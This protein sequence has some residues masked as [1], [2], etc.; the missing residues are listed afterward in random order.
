MAKTPAAQ[1]APETGSDPQ[2]ESVSFFLKVQESSVLEKGTE[3][4]LER[5]A[6]AIGRAHDKADIVIA[7]DIKVSN[8]HAIL[9]LERGTYIVFDRDSVSGTF[10]ND[11]EI[12]HG[13]ALAMGDRLKIG[14][15][16]FTF[17]RRRQWVQ[18]RRTLVELARQPDV[19]V[20]I[21][22]IILM[23]AV[24]LV[25]GT[26]RPHII[27]IPSINTGSDYKK[28]DLLENDIFPG[29]IMNWA[30]PS[31]PEGVERKNDVE[32]AKRCFERGM[33]YYKTK[34]LEFGHA[35][36]AIAWMK[37]AKAFLPADI[38]PS[39]VPFDYEE[40]DK[41]ILGSKRYLE[42]MKQRYF[43]G[44][45]RARAIRDYQNA[46][47]CMTCLRDSFKDVKSEVRGEHYEFCEGILME[48]HR[49]LGPN[50]FM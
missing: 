6:V 29:N 12:R 10:V 31:L 9:Q 2:V 48:L 25:G 42:K 27:E 20:A 50:E 33:N 17:N 18:Q 21:A 16:V 22:V 40:I 35:F 46:V 7:K 4:V 11:K 37:R 24:T 14:D 32:K 44:F 49:D 19:M 5:Q 41:T 43:D 39:E 38:A 3:I 45:N 28:S 30:V 26:F 23:G 34:A 36:S 8:L 13:V 1:T 15:T 47:Y